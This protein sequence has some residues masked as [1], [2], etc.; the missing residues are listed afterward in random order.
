LTPALR[1]PPNHDKQV[2]NVWAKRVQCDEVWAFCGSKAKNTT[3]E[4]RAE[5]MGDVWTWTA[6]DADS[7]IILSWTVGGRD[8]E[9]PGC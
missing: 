5:G 4:K 7:K 2:R 8:A 9:A 6:L 1:A 3:P